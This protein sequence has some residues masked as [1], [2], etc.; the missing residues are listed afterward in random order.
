MN[1][2]QLLSSYYPNET[3]QFEVCRYCMI[4]TLSIHGKTLN[5]GTRTYIMGI[6]NLTPDSFSGDGLLMPDSNTEDKKIDLD[7][8]L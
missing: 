3:I 8:I 1:N 7:Q 6:L 5:W 4:T 2:L